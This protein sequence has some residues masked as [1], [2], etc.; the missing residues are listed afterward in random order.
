[1]STKQQFH[2]T[3]TVLLSVHND[4]VL[5]TDKGLISALVLLDLSSAFDTVD[6]NIPLSVLY[7]SFCIKDTALNLFTSYLYQIALSHSS[8]QTASAVHCSAPQ[9]SV[10]SP[11]ECISCTEDITHH[12]YL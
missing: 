2:S 7:E 12:S 6:Q 8:F 4:L 11:L 1:M 9:G 3:E 10:H 5:A